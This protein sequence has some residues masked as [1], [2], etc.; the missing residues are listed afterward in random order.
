L[1]RSKRGGFA[2]VETTGA[3]NDFMREAT[4]YYP[5]VQQQMIR[6]VIVHP[7]SFLLPELGEEFVRYAE[8]KLCER[9]IEVMKGLRG[10]N[11]DGSIVRLSDGTSSPAATLIWRE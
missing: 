6:A 4:K 11:Y 10:V 3:V 1:N 2:G 5:S 8:R 7:G 9:K